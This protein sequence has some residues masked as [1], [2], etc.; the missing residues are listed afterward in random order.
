MFT[1]KHCTC[2]V[3][4]CYCSWYS[5]KTTTMDWDILERSNEDFWRVFQAADMVHDTKIEGLNMP[6]CVQQGIDIF[7]VAQQ[8][9]NYRFNDQLKWSKENYHTFMCIGDICTYVRVHVSYGCRSFFTTA[10]S[11]W[12][13]C[14]A[15]SRFLSFTTPPRRCYVDRLNSPT[16]CNREADKSICSFL[17][18]RN[19]STFLSVLFSFYG[20]SYMIGIL[21]TPLYS[22]GSMS[23][24]DWLH[25][26]LIL[27][28]AEFCF[29]YMFDMSSDR[30]Y[31]IIWLMIMFF[32]IN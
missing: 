20:V 24:W 5:N 18:A 1:T 7:K 15:K 29:R 22:S 21:W 10:K 30:K 26:Q 11:C 12:L 31:S 13:V 9:R 23:L 27:S 4:I 17:N 16:Y 14:A 25:H 6:A 2:H 3:K 19:I 32:K 8:I 28:K